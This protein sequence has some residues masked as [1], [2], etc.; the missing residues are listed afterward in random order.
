MVEFYSISH[1][2]VV[3]KPYN[4]QNINS[5]III[6]V[7]LNLILSTKYDN[8]I[9]PRML[10]VFTFLPVYYAINTKSTEITE[11]HVIHKTA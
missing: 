6:V 4:A 7:T 1:V 10:S 11:K 2:K 5:R 3:T 9:S 8:I